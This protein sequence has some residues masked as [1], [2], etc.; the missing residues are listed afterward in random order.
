MDFSLVWPRII[1]SAMA[2]L[3]ANPDYELVIYNTGDSFIE[4]VPFLRDIDGLVKENV[5]VLER[6]FYEELHI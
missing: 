2:E 1:E 5:K 4:H 3:Q 6:M